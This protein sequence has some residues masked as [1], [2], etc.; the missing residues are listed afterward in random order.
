[1]EIAVNTSLALN[2][3]ALPALSGHAFGSQL[4]GQVQPQGWRSLEYISSCDGRVDC[5]YDNKFGLET[6]NSLVEAVHTAFAHHYPLILSPD[7]LWLCILQGLAQHVHLHA[8]QLRHNFVDFSGKQAIVV[9]DD[10]LVRGGKNDWSSVIDLF[11]IGLRQYLDSQVADGLLCDFSTSGSTELAASQVALMDVMS[12]Y[13]SYECITE[14]GIP[15]V[16]LE[17]KV[18]DWESLLSKAQCLRQYDLGWWIDELQPVLEKL[19][20]AANGEV[21]QA[22]WQSI[23]KIH[24][25]SGGPYING[26]LLAFFPYLVSPDDPPSRNDLMDVWRLSADTPDAWKLTAGITT[27]DL[28]CGLSQ[29]P[30]VWKYMGVELKMSFLSGF[31]GVKQDKKTLALAPHIGYAVVQVQ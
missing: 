22:F 7:A 14:C 27:S 11:T 15:S 29:A 20:K 30:F 3:R 16:T 19:V 9:E 28:P 4:V 5:G 10:T 17:G 18:A 24:Q 2:D 31:L 26:W 25:G 1:M 23:Y 8:E 6:H 13:F 12:S 21:D